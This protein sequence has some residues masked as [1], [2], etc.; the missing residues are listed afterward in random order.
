MYIYIYMYIQ[1]HLPEPMLRLHPYPTDCV[2]RIR[3]HV[4]HPSK[5]CPA[6]LCKVTCVCVYLFCG[7]ARSKQRTGDQVGSPPGNPYRRSLALLLL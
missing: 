5:L 2:A 4:N 6:C 1:S 3:A 7:V